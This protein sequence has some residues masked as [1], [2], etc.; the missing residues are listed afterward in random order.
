MSERPRVLIIGGHVRSGT[1]MLGSVA[2]SHPRVFVMHELRPFVRLNRPWPVHLW[3]IKR[4]RDVLPRRPGMARKPSRR[5]FLW[6]MARYAFF[7]L[8]AWRIE[9]DDVARALAHCWPDSD[10]IG[11]QAAQNNRRMLRL[12]KNRQARV[13]IIY[14]DCRDVVQST[15]RRVRTDWARK[16]GLDRLTAARVARRWV[17]MMDQ[18]DRAGD[19]VLKIRYETF[20][21]DPRPDVERLAAFIGVN[22]DGF[23]TNFIRQDSVGKHRSGLTDEEMATVMAIAGPTLRRLGYIE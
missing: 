5:A 3:Q 18:L 15:L 11:D 7:L 8:P 4:R 16:P 20:V 6:F 10:V 9:F 19:R 1:T 23:R 22:A 12:S 2:N 14:R 21:A 17:H 13:V